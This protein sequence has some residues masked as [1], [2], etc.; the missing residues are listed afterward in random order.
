MRA[1][2]ARRL[3][4]RGWKVGDATEFLGLSAEE[5]ALVELRLALSR[6]VRARRLKMGVSQVELA[7]R[8]GSS[9]SRVAKLEGADATVSIELLIRGLLAL[10]AS[11]RDI[12]RAMAAR[13]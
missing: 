11:R 7:A 3:R 10:G 5:A 12:G 9:Q 8:L 6:S 2:T 13:T 4:A 1:D